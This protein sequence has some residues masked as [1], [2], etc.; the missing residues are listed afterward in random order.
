LPIRGAHGPG[1]ASHN[2]MAML[3]RTFLADDTWAQ[4]EQRLLSASASLAAS[5]L[6]HG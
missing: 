1:A 5:S 2:G 6:Q 3:R 4:R